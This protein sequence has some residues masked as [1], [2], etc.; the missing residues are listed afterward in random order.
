MKSRKRRLAWL[1]VLVM[2]F[3]LIGT[4][5]I[6][7]SAD[8]KQDSYAAWAAGVT[9]ETELAAKKTIWTDTSKSVDERVE[10][11]LS[12]MTLDEKIGQMAQPEQNEANGGA[13]PEDVKNYAIGSM[14]SAGGSIP[15]DGNSVENWA[16]RV[17]AYKKAALESRLGIP[18]IYG[19]DAVHGHNNVDDLVLFPHNIGFAAADDVALAEKVGQAEAEE[20]RATGIQW[21]FTHAL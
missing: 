4:G 5:G 16:D 6:T 3:S 15:P 11:L 8:T 19:V 2:A 18:L 13:S 20:I 10:A 1:L 21:T 17:N 9:D 12:V 14:F 7:A